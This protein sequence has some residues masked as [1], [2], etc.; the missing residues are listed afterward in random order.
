MKYADFKK[1]VAAMRDTQNV[2]FKTRNQ[3]ALIA[4]KELERKV[5]NELKA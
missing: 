3:R 2:Y 1:L 4:A 5:D